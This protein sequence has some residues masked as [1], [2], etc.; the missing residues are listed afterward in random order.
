MPSPVRV[1]LLSTRHDYARRNISIMVQY[2]RNSVALTSTG[3]SDENAWTGF[4]HIVCAELSYVIFKRSILFAHLVLKIKN[5]NQCWTTT[6]TLQGTIGRQHFD[7]HTYTLGFYWATS[8]SLKPAS[9]SLTLSRW[10]QASSSCWLL[11]V[12]F[13]WLGYMAVLAGLKEELMELFTAWSVWR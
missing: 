8:R 4:I 9:N 5:Y 13:C 3:A 12:S 7:E 11:S 6:R 2:R 10:S 1:P